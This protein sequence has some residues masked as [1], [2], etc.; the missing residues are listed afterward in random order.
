MTAKDGDSTAAVRRQYEDYPYPPRDPAAEAKGLRLG[1][2]S[3]LWELNHYLFA[4]RRDFTRPFQV[5]V[6][7][8]GTGDGLIMLA[9]QLADA[10]TPAEILYLDLSDASREIAEARA[11]ARRLS[12][13]RFLRGDLRAAAEHGPFDYIDCCGVL[14]HLDDPAEG[15]A[16]LRGALAD[17]GGMGVMVYGAAG[18]TGVYH[19]QAL[20]KQIVAD[21]PNPARVAMAKRLLGDLPPTNWLARNPFVEDHKTLSDAGIYDL[22]LHST[23]RAYDI[24][25]LGA[26]VEAADLRIAALIEPARYEPDTYLH[27]ETLRAAVAGL[28]WLQRCHFAELLAGNITKHI[29]YL[30]H[31]A[32]T[33]DTV[34]R[35]DDPTAIPVM[36]DAPGAAIARAI[37]SGGRITVDAGGMKIDAAL[38]P[39]AAAMLMQIDGKRTL[40][41]IRAALDPAPDA[42]AFGKQFAALYRV[43][44]GFNQMYLRF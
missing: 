20:L 22:L 3:H 6:A 38:P 12:S 40:N 4:G 31:G 37:G 43:L 29:A 33:A 15:F 1:S 8:G 17:N 2:P 27:D 25:E 16:A 44:N 26:L 34:A 11:R 5:L 7:G 39:L 10:G 14:H 35:P 28:G 36:R 23:D 21:L 32:N 42:E 19:I 18:R 13:I 41:Q 30:V 24:L 9:Q